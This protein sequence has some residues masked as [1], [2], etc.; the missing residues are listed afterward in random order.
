VDSGNSIKREYSNTVFKVQLAASSNKIEPKSYNFNGLKNISR[1]QEGKLYKYFYGDTS[2][3]N[4][5]KKMAEVA[6]SKG[7]PT[8]FIVAYQNGQRVALSSVINSPSN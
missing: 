4:E 5:I 7:Y 8:S 2:D 6:K 3:Y 1:E